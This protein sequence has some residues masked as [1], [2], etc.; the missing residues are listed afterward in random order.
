MRKYIREM[1]RRQAE[2]RGFKPSK[3]V[4][5]LWVRYQNEKR[6]EFVRMANAAKGTHKKKLW[7]SRIAMAGK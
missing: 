1:I 4:H 7:P 5:A 2:K 3:T 6:G